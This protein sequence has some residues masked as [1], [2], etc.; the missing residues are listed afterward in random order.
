LDLAS[1]PSLRLASASGAMPPK[2]TIVRSI[3]LRAPGGHRIDLVVEL[4]GIHS[5][6]DATVVNEAITRGELPKGHL[7]YTA[8]NLPVMVHFV[9]SALQCMPVVDMSRLI[10]GNA[11]CDYRS[12]GRRIPC[13]SFWVAHAARGERNLVSEGF[14]VHCMIGR[15]VTVSRVSAS[16]SADT[17]Y[18]WHTSARVLCLFTAGSEAGHL[19][20][21]CCCF[22]CSG[23]GRGPSGFCYRFRLCFGFCDGSREE[24]R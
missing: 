17:A 15:R 2:R 24:G 19:R 16:Q 18:T 3:A 7:S 21:W 12:S 5:P 10:H 22:P 4:P 23:C 14:V 20:R 6:S 11:S 1:S 9:P 13:P 8:V